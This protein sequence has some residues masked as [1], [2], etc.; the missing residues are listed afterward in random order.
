MRQTRKIQHSKLWVARWKI[1]SC[2]KE[3]KSWNHFQIIW[4]QVDIVCI[5]FNVSKPSIVNALLKLTPWTNLT[6]KM[7]SQLYFY[8]NYNINWS[9]NKIDSSSVCVIEKSCCLPID[10]DSTTKTTFPHLYT[11]LKLCN[12]NTWQAFGIDQKESLSAEI[13]REREREGEGEK[14]RDR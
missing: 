13:Q 14:E 6:M 9:S 11:Q 3:T 4:F 5:C 8:H 2:L 12:V 10:F 7:K 1:Q